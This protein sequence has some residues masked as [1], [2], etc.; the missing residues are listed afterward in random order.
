[1]NESPPETISVSVYSLA[2][3]TTGRVRYVGRTIHPAKRLVQHLRWGQERYNNPAKIPWIDGLAER[4][5]EPALTVLEEVSAPAGPD[6]ERR[7]IAHFRATH[8]DLLNI[9]D[10]GGTSD[11]GP[12]KTV[13]DRPRANETEEPSRP[14][15]DTPSQRPFSPGERVRAQEALFSAMRPLVGRVYAIRW[16]G[17]DG[18]VS[19]A[20]PAI[21]I[22]QLSRNEALRCLA[23]LKG[24]SNESSPK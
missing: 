4:G 10:G 22:F 1:M 20:D 24:R 12:R 23:P 5:L 13:P 6:A 9:T 15:T 3:P 16:C 17:G 14:K 7:W 8:D 21:G 2:D 11:Y 18:S 19:L